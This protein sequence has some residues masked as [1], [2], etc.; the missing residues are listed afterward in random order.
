MYINVYLMY[1]NKEVQTMP[2]ERESTDI[3]KAMAYDLQKSFHSNAN[4]ES[5]T[6]EEIDQIID[7]YIA[8]LAQK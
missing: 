4:K 1:Q 5:Y 2:T 3:K 8:G 7:A 6:V